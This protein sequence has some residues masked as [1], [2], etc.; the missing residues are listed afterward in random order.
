ML[1]ESEDANAF[2]VKND[3]A[4]LI[5]DSTESGNFFHIF[6]RIKS[7]MNNNHQGQ[8]VCMV[9]ARWHVHTI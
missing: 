3:K 1:K 4:F 7:P 5:G 8:F 6:G 2:R 9:K